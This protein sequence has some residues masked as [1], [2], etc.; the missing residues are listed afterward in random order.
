MSDT[1]SFNEEPLENYVF[2]LE[3]APEFDVEDIEDISV[4]DSN[5]RDE[6]EEPDESETPEVPNHD[7]RQGGNHVNDLYAEWSA[8]P[9]QNNLSLLM[10]DVRQFALRIIRKKS[11]KNL[12]AEDIAQVATSNVWL[13]LPSFKVTSKFS[14]WVY[15]IT[16]N[17]L[18]DFI[19][20]DA[21]RK[22]DVFYEWKD[23]Q[24]DG[25][26]RSVPT[27]VS[28]D[29][30]VVD[31]SPTGKQALLPKPY[32]DAS[33]NGL[34]A[35]IDLQLVIRKLSQRD[36]RLLSRRNCRQHHPGYDQ[37]SLR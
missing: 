21:R 2:E 33:E 10:E 32:Q 27:Q 30:D 13:K 8:A 1:T 24:T 23:Y 36:Q 12:N 11:P 20:Q 14:S 7:T 28:E 15:A 6:F 34:N 18:V 22:E 4:E 17:T 31:S 16:Y 19:R 25:G 5:L 35:E 9:N 37:R 3:T 26:T 29:D